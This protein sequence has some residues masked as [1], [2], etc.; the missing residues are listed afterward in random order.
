MDDPRIREEGRPTRFLPKVLLRQDAGG[1]LSGSTPKEIFEPGA[2][3]FLDL[4]VVLDAFR[5]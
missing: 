2:V 1:L 3:F 5:L 4:K